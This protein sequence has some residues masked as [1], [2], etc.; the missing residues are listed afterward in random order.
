[1]NINAIIPLIG[2]LLALGLKVADIIERAD[3]VS[4]EDKEALKAAIRAAKESVTPWSPGEAPSPP[5]P[6]N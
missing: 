5:P 4:V 3:D 1:M 2:Q 6:S